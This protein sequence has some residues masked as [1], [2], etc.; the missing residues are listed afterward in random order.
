MFEKLKALEGNWYGRMDDITEELEELGVDPDCCFV[1]REY[2][3][4]SV[5]EDGED[6]EVLIRLG[7]T[8]N[9]ITIDS[10]ELSRM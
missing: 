3:G 8:E 4:A 9:T 1:C 10:V 2:I 6:L 7:G 5:E